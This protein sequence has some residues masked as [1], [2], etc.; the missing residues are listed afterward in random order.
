MALE[1][2]NGG[3]SQARAGRAALRTESGMMLSLLS[4]RA[5][6]MDIASFMEK[7]KR[8]WETSDE[9]LLAS[10]FSKEA[11]ISQYAFCRATR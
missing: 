7:Y 5:P 6:K 8:A 1:G 4:S 3:S 9:D 2:T 10:L 11:D